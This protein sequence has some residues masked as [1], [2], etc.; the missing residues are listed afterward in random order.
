MQFLNA[1]SFHQFRGPILLF[2][3][4]T[5]RVYIRKSFAVLLSI[6]HVSVAVHIAIFVALQHVPRSQSSFHL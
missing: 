1:F 2:N 4:D 5:Q 6:N 3:V